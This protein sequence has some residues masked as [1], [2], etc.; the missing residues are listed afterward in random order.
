MLKTMA[1]KK[2]DNY[3]KSVPIFSSCYLIS[4]HDSDISYDSRYTTI[5]T[6][7]NNHDFFSSNVLFKKIEHVENPM[8]GLVI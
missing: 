5:S 3:F 4:S 7:Y 1:I 6:F 2:I 8:T